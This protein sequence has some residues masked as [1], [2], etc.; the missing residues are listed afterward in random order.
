MAEFSSIPRHGIRVN[1]QSFQ[2]TVNEDRAKLTSCHAALPPRSNFDWDNKIELIAVFLQTNGTGNCG[3]L[4]D[5]NSI[6]F[7]NKKKHRLKLFRSMITFNSST[8]VVCETFLF[9]RMTGFSI[10]FLFFW[11]INRTE[12]NSFFHETKVSICWN[13]NWI[14]L[15]SWL[16][17]TSQRQI[18]WNGTHELELIP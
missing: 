12:K 7:W 3:N 1:N 14:E 4:T 17:E 11:K 15:N 6:D 8:F 18:R 10:T 9:Y 2:Q 16:L 5:C 13:P